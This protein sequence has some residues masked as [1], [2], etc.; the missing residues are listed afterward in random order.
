MPDPEKY[1]YIH[2]MFRKI[3]QDYSP[4]VTPKSIDEAVIDLTHTLSLFK[5]GVTDI[6]N[7]IKKRFR[8]RNWRVDAMLNRRVDQPL[9]G[10]TRRLPAQ[11]GWP[12]HHRPH[13]RP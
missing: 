2:R 12:G 9:P 1:R 10:K 8:E 5:G 6:G 4:D 3:F 7:E 13:Q 11:T